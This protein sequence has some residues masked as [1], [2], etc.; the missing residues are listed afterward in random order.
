MNIEIFKFSKKHKKI[1]KKLIDLTKV[2]QVVTTGYSFIVVYQRGRKIELSYESSYWHAKKDL[3][4]SNSDVGIT[5][6][7]IKKDKRG[8]CH[9]DNYLRDSKGRLLKDWGKIE[10]LHEKYPKIGKIWY[11]S[12]EETDKLLKDFTYKNG[13]LIMV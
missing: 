6:S 2:K 12:R 13:N 7:Y 9:K 3:D 8:P 1:N 11:I 10:E 5:Y 4:N